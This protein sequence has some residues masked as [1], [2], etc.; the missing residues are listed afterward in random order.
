MRKQLERE[1]DHLQ[2]Q[3]DSGEITQAEYNKEARELERDYREAAREAGDAARDRELEA[4]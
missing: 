1:E 3:L 2:Q 4:W